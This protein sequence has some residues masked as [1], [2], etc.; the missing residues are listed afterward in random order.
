MSHRSLLAWA[1]FLLLAL[2]VVAHETTDIFQNQ[3]TLKNSQLPMFAFSEHD[4]W[5]VEVLYQG[6]S[7]FFERDDHGNWFLHDSSH[8]HSVTNSHATPESER[9]N[10]TNHGVSTEITK[11]LDMTARMIAD[12]KLSPEETVLNQHQVDGTAQKVEQMDTEPNPCI[13]NNVDSNSLKTPN[14]CLW[15]DTFGLKTPEIIVS[16]Y[17]RG[18]GEPESLKPL[19]ILYVGDML[20]SEYTYY[21]MKDGDKEIYLIPRYFITMLLGVTFGTNQAPSL[22]PEK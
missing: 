19:E 17:P 16:F 7:A 4:L 14:G 5:R 18:N 13:K 3:P 15:L 20:P 9:H 12:R 21:A 10:H 22:M 1:V 8:T 2:G 6:R 11:Q